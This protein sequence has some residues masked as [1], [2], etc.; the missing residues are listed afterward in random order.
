[1]ISPTPNQLTNLQEEA[2]AVLQHNVRG[3][4]ITPSDE[5]YGAN[6]NNWAYLW[7]TAFSVMAI[8]DY[9]PPLAQKLFNTYLAAQHDNG[10]VPHMV[11]WSSGFPQGW[12][13]TNVNWHGFRNKRRDL[14]DRPVKTSTIT[15]PP[16]L[17]VAAGVIIDNLR[18]ADERQ[19]FARLT[20][21]KLAAYHSWLYKEREI[22][23]DGLVATVHPHETGRDDAPS[24]KALLEAIPLSPRDRLWMSAPVKTIFERSRMDGSKDLAERSDTHTVMRAA[25]LAMFHTPPQLRSSQ[26]LSLTHQYQ[27]IDPG[28]NAILD[29]ANDELKRLAAE[30]CMAVS[31]EL[32]SAMER[33]TQG[34]QQLWSPADHAFRGID[35]LGRVVL[36]AG[37]EIGDILPLYSNHLTHE[38][39]DA[40]TGSLADTQRFGG[41]HLP[42]VSRESPHYDADRFWQGADWPQIRLLM[43]DGLRRRP[44]DRMHQLAQGLADS[45]IA[46]SLR[47]R[48]LPEYHDSMT[49]EPKGAARFSWGA[50]LILGA[51][52]TH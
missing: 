6:G 51:L 23:S 8:A 43:M 45:A 3:S 11:M 48:S 9:D 16:M 1:M 30:A 37:Q 24:H 2:V 12:L 35:A 10:M 31:S 7:D 52:K 4:F 15:Q 20:Y 36:P 19:A 13:A 32:L 39:V 33:T 26:R 21:P 34:I 50:A 44:T 25:A 40:L 29:R 17:A 28:F 49:G 14:E 42:S 46:R 22:N 38:Q 47:T 5:L 27:H 18:N 41:P